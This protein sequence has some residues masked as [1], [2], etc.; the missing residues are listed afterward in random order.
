M[1]IRLRLRSRG[2]G[3]VQ[4]V[5]IDENGAQ[6]RGGNL[7][8]FTADGTIAFNKSVGREI[9]FPLIANGVIKEV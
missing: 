3:G 1:D 7:V 4:L 6:M 8:H 2:D 9:G 5:A